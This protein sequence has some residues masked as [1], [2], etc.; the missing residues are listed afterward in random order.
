MLPLGT[1][2]QDIPERLRLYQDTRKARADKILHYTRM[3]GLYPKD[4]KD[5]KYE[6]PDRKHALRPNSTTEY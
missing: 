4:L 1:S 2:K 5:S 3:A 6:R